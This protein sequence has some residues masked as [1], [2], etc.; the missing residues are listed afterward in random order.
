MNLE[1]ASARLELRL[2]K[3]GGGEGG[4]G[5]GLETFT[6]MSG[7]PNSFLLAM[8]MANA[9]GPLSVVRLFTQICKSQ[10]PY[11]FILPLILSVVHR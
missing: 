7:V 3:A 9:G 5:A 8:D 1:N 10:A 6:Q 2:K 11:H 4:E